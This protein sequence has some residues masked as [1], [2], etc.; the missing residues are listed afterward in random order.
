MA[1]S[2]ITGY[3]ALT[4]PA[5]TD[6]LEVV[7]VSDTSMAGTSTNKQITVAN[8]LDFAQGGRYNVRAYGAVGDNSTD[9]TA[10]FQAAI[11]ACA[12]ANGGIVWVPPSTN[13][14]LISQ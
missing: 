2:K 11:N 14:Y 10:A 7:D 5:L 8:L 3:G 9:D 6:L 13:A 1:D 12:T 4:A